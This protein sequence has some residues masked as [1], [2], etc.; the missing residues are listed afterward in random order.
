MSYAPPP[1]PRS[2]A[3]EPEGYRWTSDEIIKKLPESASIQG[4]VF[5]VTGTNAGL[6]EETARVLSAYGATVVMGSRNESAAK[7]SKK[8][9]IARHPKASLKWIFLDLSDLQSVKDFVKQFK[10]L[11][12]PLNGLICNAGIMA[13]PYETTKQGFEM[14]FG[15]NHLAHFLLIQLLIDDL[16]KAGPGSR[17]VCVSSKGHRFSGVRYDDIGFEGGKKYDPFEGYGQSKTANILCAK[18]FNEIYSKQ[19]VECFSLHPGMIPTELSKNMSPETRDTMLK[20]NIPNPFMRTFVKGA[21]MIQ[22]YIRPLVGTLKPSWMKTVEQGAAT[23]VF[24]A[25]SPEL[26]G[27]GGV[28]LEDCHIYNPLTEEAADATGENAKRLFALS[29]TLVA[30]Y[31]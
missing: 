18:A 15:V 27:K 29:E 26:N 28:Y 30:E 4:K 16:V 23:Q 8:R 9:I 25:T 12:I 14:Q 1:L 6:G 3:E 17:V 31:K 20:G 11:G 5:I 13:C 24:A 19:G 7:E 10:A 2:K 21:M 22:P